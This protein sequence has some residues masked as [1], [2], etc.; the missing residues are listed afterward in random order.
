MIEGCGRWEL[1]SHK[2]VNVRAEVRFQPVHLHRERADAVVR[3]ARRLNH[4]NDLVAAWSMVAVVDSFQAIR[5]VPLLTAV[6]RARRLHAICQFSGVDGLFGLAPNGS[7]AGGR[8]R[9]GGI[10][11]GLLPTKRR[12]S[13][14]I[15]PSE[16][17]PRGVRSRL[18]ACP[19]CSGVAGRRY[20][21]AYYR[22]R[23]RCLED[24]GWNLPPQN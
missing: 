23:C 2:V 19:S 17:Q 1:C 16:C 22:R 5:G 6:T 13:A 14:K 9:R 20:G 10:A 7:S 15:T 3:I 12:G 24:V 4:I 11:Q 21:A 8:T 18:G